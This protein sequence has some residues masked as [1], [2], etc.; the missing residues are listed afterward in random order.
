MYYH[1]P[2]S[3]DRQHSRNAKNEVSTEEPGFGDAAVR[4]HWF[5]DES[6]ESMHSLRVN[7]DGFAGSVHANLD[8]LNKQGK[9]VLLS[10]F[11][12]MKN[13]IC[14]MEVGEQNHDNAISEPLAPLRQRTECEDW[15]MQGEEGM[16]R[17]FRTSPHSQQTSPDI[18]VTAPNS[19]PSPAFSDH[20][21]ATP[22]ATSPHD[23][24]INQTFMIPSTSTS[25]HAQSRIPSPTAPPMQM[26]PPLAPWSCPSPM[27]NCQNAINQPMIHPMNHPMNQPMN[28]PINQPMNHPIN[29]PLMTQPLMNQPLMTQPLTQPLMTNPILTNPAAPNQIYNDTVQPS[30]QPSPVSSFHPISPQPFQPSPPPMQQQQPQ[31]QP[32]PQQ[33]QN[34][35][36]EDLL[37][38][39]AQRLQRDMMVSARP[40]KDKRFSGD[41]RSV[42]FEA[43]I[44][45]FEMVTADKALTDS[46]RFLELMHW[47]KGNALQVVSMYELE[48]DPSV[49]L[50]QAKAHLRKDYGRQNSSATMMLEE[51]LAGKRIQENEPKRFQGFVL[52]LQHIYKKAEQTGRASTFNSPDLI[53]TILRKKFDFLI[54]KWAEERVK[55]EEQWDEEPGNCNFDMDFNAF[56]LFLRRHQKIAETNQLIGGFPRAT[57]VVHTIHTQEDDPAEI[58]N[59]P[60]TAQAWNCRFCDEASFHPLMKCKT[61]LAKGAYERYEMLRMGGWCAKC[62]GRRHKARD[63]PMETSCER[64]N[65]PHHTLMHQDPPDQAL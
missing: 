22:L 18:S 36:Q 45:R 43:F 56:L 65:G 28:H 48:S 59:H 15:V 9:A 52:S 58:V 34:T 57:A 17:P 31:Q 53:N 63:C 14:T 64:C 41:D 61:F 7:M 12:L 19:L 60:P 26:T 50:K 46:M 39:S 11:E 21:N 55:M 10:V 37:R 3:S 1:A 47:C 33:P 40:L 32:A 2:L 44:N 54:K 35:I 13:F 23:E 25:T 27:V 38:V 29:Q 51:L 42:D 16:T 8:S 24:G 30:L 5:G 20:W 4:A 6:M 62:L 49:A